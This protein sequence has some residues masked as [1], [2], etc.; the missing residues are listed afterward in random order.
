MNNF[1]YYT[2]TKIIFEKNAEERSGEFLKLQKAKKVLIHYGSGSV[3]KSGLLDKVKKSISDAGIEFVELGGVVPNPLL[4]KVYEGIELC[5]SENVDFIFAVGGGSTI[6]SAKAIALGLAYDGD[7][8][9]FFEGKAKPKTSYPVACVLTIAAAGSEMSTDTVITKDEGMLKRFTGHEDCICKFSLLN[10]E[11]T[12]T[13]PDYQ[14][15]S[16]CVDIIMHTMERYFNPTENL[17][18]TDRMAEGVLISAI[19]NAKKLKD[20]PQD[21]EARSNIMW[22]GSLT[23]NGLTGCGTNGGDW[24]THMIEHELGG[25]FNVA[26]GAGLSAVW[27]SWARYVVDIIPHRF[28]QYGIRVLGI[29]E[30]ATEKETALLAIEKTEEFF[31]YINMPISIPELGITVTAE[32]IEEM[33]IKGTRFETQKIG[34]VKPLDKQDFINIYTNANK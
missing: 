19:E 14:T 33:A 12:L 27:G 2:P 21:L 22:A 32:N 1:T 26:H 18:I 29:K 13:L 5:K 23:H 30:Q 4:S 28:A 9:D 25:M 3:I 6:D 7:V 15:A 24:S 20:N 8:W 31:K 17:D 16:G 10:P 11:L 34:A